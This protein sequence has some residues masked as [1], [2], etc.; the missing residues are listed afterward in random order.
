MAQPEHGWWQQQLQQLNGNM[1]A[2]EQQQQQQPPVTMSAGCNNSNSVETA[3]AAAAAISSVPNSSSASFPTWQ[4]TYTLAKV[5]Q[6]QQQRQQ[7]Q[8]QQP[9]VHLST[10]SAVLD[11]S[12][13]SSL[14]WQPTYTLAHLYANG[15]ESVG[16]HTD[17]LTM[18]GPLPTIASVSL[19]T[20]RM[21]RLR[22]ANEAVAAKALAA[23]QLSTAPANSG[24]ASVRAVGSSSSSRV[25][26]KQLANIDRVLPDRS[27]LIMWPPCQEEWRHEVSCTRGASKKLDEHP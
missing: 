25:Q 22:P 14:T 10:T 21:F 13:A 2:K 27:L 20:A 24:A 26:A 5:Q 19:G 16:Q 15:S 8:Q 12:S 4:P 23:L 9:P 6:Q 3:A 18:I 7:Q 17:R 11:S 1:F